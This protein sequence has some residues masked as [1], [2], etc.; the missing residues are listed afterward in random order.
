TLTKKTMSQRLALFRQITSRFP[1]YWPGWYDYANYMVHWT[2]YIGTQSEDAR[3]ALERTVQLNPEFASGWEHLFWIA[4]DQRDT[5]GARRALREMERMSS[6]TGYRLNQFLVNAYRIVYDLTA[7]GG[8][9]PAAEVQQQ[10]RSI[11]GYTGPIEPIELGTGFIGPG[12]PR[13]QA[14]LA[15]AVLGFAPPRELA[16]AMW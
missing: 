8:T 6:T 13:G 5:V 12:F 15:T 4:I 3:T 10:A 11:A 14:Q 1:T 16:A 2:P 7:H 9:L